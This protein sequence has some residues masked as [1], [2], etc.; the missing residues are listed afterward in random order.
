[1]AVTFSRRPCLF[2]LPVISQFERDV[3]VPTILF[4]KSRLSFPGDVGYLI[5]T[6]FISWAG[7]IT[8]SSLMDIFLYFI[9]LLLSQVFIICLLSAAKYQHFRGVLTTYIEKHFSATMAY[10]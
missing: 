5:D 1:M 6:S 7:W 4:E 2:Y 9:L 10:K 3:E 8:L